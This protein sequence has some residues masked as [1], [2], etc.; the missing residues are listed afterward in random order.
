M[1]LED[2][3]QKDFVRRQIYSN[4]IKQ[5]LYII[6]FIFISFNL[7]IRSILQLKNKLKKAKN[8]SKITTSKREIKKTK[9]IKIKAKKTKIKTKTIKRSTKVD[10]KANAK[11]IAIATT[12]ITNQKRLLRLR[13][14]FVCTHVSFVLKIASMLLSCLL[15]FNNS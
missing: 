14:Q 9:K 13:E 12:I 10:A 6:N 5:L 1:L 15:L 11:A 4:N 7:Q 3:Q 8:A 2:I